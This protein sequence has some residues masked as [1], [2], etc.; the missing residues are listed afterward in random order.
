[1]NNS[2]TGEPSEPSHANT[3]CVNHIRQQ[4]ARTAPTWGDR[5][6]VV[7]PADIQGVPAL[8]PPTHHP[9]YN[10]WWH[11]SINTNLETNGPAPPDPWLDQARQWLHQRHRTLYAHPAGWKCFPTCHPTTLQ[12]FLDIC[13][14]PQKASTTHKAF[15]RL[16]WMM[17]RRHWNRSCTLNIEQIAVMNKEDDLTHANHLIMT[18][19]RKHDMAEPR[20][21]RAIR[22]KLDQNVQ[23]TTLWHH[24]HQEPRPPPEPDPRLI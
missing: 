11:P 9:W 8:V 2:G 1:M 3:N 4:W 22:R 5:G 7:P 10:L 6:W 16:L 15:F 20:I 21:A 12:W 23:Q 17:I 13:W 24:F 18:N 19:K 14:I